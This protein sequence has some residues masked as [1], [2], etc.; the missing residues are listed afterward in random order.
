[1]NRVG[2]S[3][4]SSLREYRQAGWSRLAVVVGP[5][6]LVRG[7]VRDRL[8]QA[9]RV[10]PRDPLERREL[11]VLDPFPGPPT[12]DLFRLVQPD[13]GL[14]RRVV[15]RI[16]R[17]PDRRF[18]RYDAPAAP[19]PRSGDRRGPAPARRVPDRCAASSLPASRR[20]GG[21]TRRLRRRCTRSPARTRRTSGPPPT[22]DSAGS[23]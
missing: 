16:P 18:D 23:P 12:V 19:T 10:I 4:E 7:H 15:V 1:M 3:P 20:S 11:D 8:E 9:A 17:A 13:E 2:F 21:R 22:V 6:E 14:G 5:L